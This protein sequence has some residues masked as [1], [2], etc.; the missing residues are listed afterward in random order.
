MAGHP[1]QKP[2]ATHIRKQANAGFWHGKRRPFRGDPKAGWRSQT[3]AAREQYINV[4]RHTVTRYVKNI[5]TLGDLAGVRIE[6]EP[7]LLGNDD[8]ALAQAGLA[9]RFDFDEKGKKKK[10]EEKKR[11][12]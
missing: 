5:R 4:L 7:V 12:I 11:T 9:V 10:R 3:D 1:W 8:L 2:A 6:H